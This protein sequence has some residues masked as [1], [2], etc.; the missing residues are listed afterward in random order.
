[1]APVSFITLSSLS[2][3]IKVAISQYRDD[4]FLQSL[5]LVE[6]VDFFIISVITLDFSNKLGFEGASITQLIVSMQL[7][8]PIV[9]RFNSG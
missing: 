7:S 8:P 4:S 6:S 5:A 9:G 3:S 1:M 2:N